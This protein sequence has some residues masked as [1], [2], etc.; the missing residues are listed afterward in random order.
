ML[1]NKFS[2]FGCLNLGGIM[3]GGANVIKADLTST[4]GVVHVIDEVILKT[5]KNM[6]DAYDYADNNKQ[7]FY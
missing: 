4:Q 1:S 5:N 2:I 7:R 6:A 3:F